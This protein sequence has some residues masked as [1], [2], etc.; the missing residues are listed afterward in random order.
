[1]NSRDVLVQV[2]IPKCAGTSVGA[3]LQESMVAGLFGGFARLYDDRTSYTEWDLWE[4]ALHDRRVAAMSSHGIRRFPEQ[5]GNRRL[6]YFT[7]LRQPLDQFRSLVRYMLQERAG[8]HLPGEIAR[9]RDQIAYMLAPDNEPELLLNAQT[10]HLALYSWCAA[11]GGRCDPEAMQSWA[12]TDRA[13]YLRQRQD[14]A[15]Q[16]LT[17]FL[18]VGTVERLRQ[19]MDVLRQRSMLVGI[20]LLSAAFVPR[21]NVTALP[22]DDSADFEAAGAV[23]GRLY[24]AL[25]DDRA[26]YAF[27]TEL[28]AAA[29]ELRLSRAN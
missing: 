18:A 12:A 20:P 11:T 17:S 9:A 22:T 14:I 3:W 24:E 4:A 1:V 6:H 23:G 7:I 29:P 8:F 28:L 27:G 21:I 2:H 16:A 25:A 19:S 13:D 10:N 26:L 15:R 5:I